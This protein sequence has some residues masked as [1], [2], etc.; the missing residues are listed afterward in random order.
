VPSPG[1]KPRADVAERR[2]KVL[3]LRI[4]QVPY[5]EIARQLGIKLSTAKSDYPRALEQLKLEQD[6]QAS[7]ARNVE[8]AKLDMLEAA[9]VGVLRRRHITV[10]HGKIVRDEDGQVVEDDAPVLAA[11]DRLVRI[12]QRRATLT[13]MDAP[14]RIE[15]DDARRAEIE[16]LA[17][18]LAAAGVGEL[19]PGGAGPAAGDAAPGQVG[20]GAA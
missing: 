6:A 8:Q 16:R 4:E 11:I 9:A 19:E 15:V 5:A 3:R 12:A 1:F 18:E 20:P 13:G 2:A 10:Q 7:T 14:V 17:A